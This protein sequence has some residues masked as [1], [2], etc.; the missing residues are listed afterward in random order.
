MDKKKGLIIYN[1][2]TEITKI[3][4]LVQRLMEA[5]KEKDLE[6]KAIKNNELLFGTDRHNQFILNGL[7]MEKPDFVLFWDKDI[8]LAELLEKMQIR[9]FNSAKAIGL[10]DDKTKMHLAL[11]SSGIPIPRTV[12]APLAYYEHNLPD[13]YFQRVQE[14]I[15]Y[16]L[17]LKE[18]FG[19]FGMQVYLI[20]DESRLRAEI[21]ELGKKNFL[22]QEY[23]AS[24]RGRDIR[25]N[26]IGNK[27]VGAMLRQNADDFR[28]NITLGGKA[29]IVELT[30]EQEE[31]AL[32]VHR[33]LGLD[34]CGLDLLFAEGEMLLC[35]VNSNVNFLS[36]EQASGVPFAEKLLD[37]IL[38][39]LETDC[40][41]R[42]VSKN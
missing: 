19:S 27:V 5:A 16:P 35:E 4:K 12:L 18:A 32:K 22:L 42:E 13:S 11:A 28:A 14:W 41:K 38:R 10:C 34:F 6:L 1:G 7:P 29:E 36:F 8:L 17:I 24:S 20:E 31:L 30:K 21:K 33:I 26:I 39:Q 15:G 37:Y 25:V 40:L 23:I 3:T 9:V 2:S